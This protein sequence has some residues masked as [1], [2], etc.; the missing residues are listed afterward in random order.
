[1]DKNITYTARVVEIVLNELD[2][3]GELTGESDT[4]LGLG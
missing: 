1:M 4:V 3:N 2:K